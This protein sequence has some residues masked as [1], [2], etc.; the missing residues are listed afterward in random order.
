[1]T[2]SDEAGRTPESSQVR[3]LRQ[4]AS[5]E[6][7][8][9]SCCYRDSGFF[10][11]VVE[12]F[13]TFVF[14]R[15]SNLNDQGDGKMFVCAQ[16]GILFLNLVYVLARIG[17]MRRE[18]AGLKQAEKNF[19]NTSGAAERS[20]A[21][22]KLKKTKAAL[23]DNLSAEHRFRIQNFYDVIPI[24]IIVAEIGNLEIR[25]ILFEPNPEY[26]SPVVLHLYLIANGGSAPVAEHYGV[27]SPF[28]N[29]FVLAYIGIF[30]ILGK[31]VYELVRSSKIRNKDGENS[32]YYWWFSTRVFN[33][34]RDFFIRRWSVPL[35]W[36]FSENCTR[37]GGKPK[38]EDANKKKDDSAITNNDLVIYKRL[39]DGMNEDEEDEE[40]E[41]SQ[42]QIRRR[43]VWLERAT[44]LEDRLE[45]RQARKWQKKN[46]S[47]HVVVSDVVQNDVAQ[48]TLTGGDDIG[49][50]K[51]ASSR[52]RGLV[53]KVLSL[54]GKLIPNFIHVWFLQ[55]RIS[56]SHW[57]HWMAN[58][59]RSEV[60]YVTLNHCLG[61]FRFD[62]LP[63]VPR[64]KSLTEK[65]NKSI[66]AEFNRRLS[67][68][69][70]G[71]KKAKTGED[72]DLKIKSVLEKA[73]EEKKKR[74]EFAKSLKGRL[75]HKCIKR[76]KYFYETDLLAEE[77]EKKRLEEEKKKKSASSAS[78][79][80]S[81]SAV[82]VMSGNSSA[83]SNT[84]ETRDS[85]LVESKLHYPLGDWVIKDGRIFSFGG[86]EEELHKRIQYWKQR[87]DVEIDDKV[88]QVNE[89]TS[90][91]LS[92]R[93]VNVARELEEHFHLQNSFGKVPP[94]PTSTGAGG[95]A[96]LPAMGSDPNLSQTFGSTSGSSGFGDTLNQTLGGSRSLSRADV[97]KRTLQKAAGSKKPETM[98][99]EDFPGVKLC[100][101]LQHDP[102]RASVGSAGS[103]DGDSSAVHC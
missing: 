69:G 99:W 81:A 20:E 18:N 32:S 85:F 84:S 97:E 24:V 96:L 23:M 42:K 80:H 26:Q 30:F 102:E 51:G 58:T 87:F 29:V 53:G 52:R 38:H 22:E 15:S 5:M 61:L 50:R 41:L 91:K 64:H 2:K 56:Y 74:D 25:K 92:E 45:Q 57:R 21:A 67:Q 95:G 44:E 28:G 68:M 101:W 13:V 78:L 37:R 98:L 11:S 83:S 17:M 7:L 35:Y 6:E 60:V 46:K 65:E 48:L 86:P 62:F 55:T 8:F 75:Y 103:G 89:K 47:D 33:F 59:P 71:R 31:F 10:D 73:R 79:P 43:R 77:A 82:S 72:F 3:T 1:M 27:F 63:F 34:L 39:T 90:F 88:L 49:I 16:F 12:P 100:K 93:D 14:Q 36:W 54:V 40:G 9:H 4:T 19:K 76:P 94:T 66:A 70:D